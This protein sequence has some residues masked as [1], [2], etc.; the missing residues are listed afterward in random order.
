MDQEL[1]LPYLTAREETLAGRM[2]AGTLL[3]G[4]SSLQPLGHV[5]DL[6]SGARRTPL[7]L[8]SAWRG[9]REIACG[10]CTQHSVWPGAG[11][12]HMITDLWF[13]Q[14]PPSLRLRTVQEVWPGEERGEAQGGANIDSGD[15]VDVLVSRGRGPGLGD[16]RTPS[17][18][19]ERR[20]A[21]ETGG[22][23][24]QRG[25]RTKPRGVRNVVPA[26]RLWRLTVG[27]L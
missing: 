18:F 8:P 10:G 14:G 1:R 12:E 5:R 23:E 16:I 19:S 15:C 7:Y 4:L 11:S 20:A 13:L 24:T 27:P 9:F 2:R 6:K 25:G 3:L 17:P 22:K 26:V 21:V